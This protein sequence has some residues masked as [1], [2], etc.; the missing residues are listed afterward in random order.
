M[1][2]R[3]RVEERI[4]EWGVVVEDTL[5]TETS[6]IAFGRRGSQPVVLKVIRQRGDEWHSGEILD[7][8]EGRGVV[9]VYEHVEGAVLL[10]RLSPGHSL[11]EIA[12]DGGDEEATEILAEVIEKMSPGQSASACVNVQEWARSFERYAASGDDQIPKGLVEGGHRIYSELCGSQ[13]HTRLL[14][15]DLHHYNI[16]FDSERGWLAIDP[17]GVVGEIEYEIGAALRNPYDRPELFAQSATAERRLKHLASRLNLDFNR[18][19]N[20]TFAQAVLSAIWSVEDGFAVGPRHPCLVLAE[21][22]RPM[23]EAGG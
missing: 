12:L 4:H 13:T 8:F 10:E 23:L 11:A 2:L 18:A 1:Q 9:R 20:W 21:A 16:L 19:L 3:T 15:G 7:A 6:F 22:I 5:E 14:H 17:K